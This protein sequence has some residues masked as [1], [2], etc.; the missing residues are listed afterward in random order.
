MLTSYGY[1]KPLVFCS[2]EASDNCKIV[3]CIYSL[4]NDRKKDDLE[5]EELVQVI[6][7]LE[8]EKEDIQ[9]QLVNKQSKKLVQTKEKTISDLGSKLEI[10]G[11]SLKK[12]AIAQKRLKEEITKARNNMDYIKT[13]YTHETKKHAQEMEK[14]QD[15]LTKLMNSNYKVNIAT[16]QMQ[17]SFPDSGAPKQ[18]NDHILQMRTAFSALTEEIKTKE[19]QTLLESEDL[20]T[21]LIKLYTGAR[22][23]LE[24]VM[25]DF[26]S[27]HNKAPR[28]V[29][30]ETACFRLP[31]EYGG[32][33]AIQ[34]VEHL[35]DR[36]SEEWEYQ[37]N[38]KPSLYTEEEMD[39]KKEMIETLQQTVEDLIQESQLMADEYDEKVK[40]YK[41]FERGGFFDT[42]MPT[43]VEPILSDSEDS[44]IDLESGND[45][46]FTKLK[47]KA[48]RE[49]KKLSKIAI[50]L[51]K[52][53][54]ILK[55]E[56]WAF[57]EVKRQFKMSEILEEEP[58]TPS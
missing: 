4:L 1:P 11:N 41:R 46:K 37:V 16:L 39:E 27:K 8:N 53:R 49:Q 43:P 33:E 44:I 34:R 28:D 7:R 19:K 51:G 13:Q 54:E 38:Q 2:T 9:E 20:R 52:E 24:G 14:L 22:R 23:L 15:R 6:R 25:K 50:E 45:V 40:I 56:E 18:E 3:N 55:K 30:Q 35:L 5:R 31:M 17:G 58:A 21:G 12:E 32:K 26:D 29:Y 36:L 10:S 57:Q 42:V 48:I 47:N